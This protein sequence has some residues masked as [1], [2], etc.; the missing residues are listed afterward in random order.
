MLAARAAEVGKITKRAANLG[1]FRHLLLCA[2][3]GRYATI[4]SEG[5]GSHADL[6]HTAQRNQ[7][8]P[9]EAGKR[10]GA[11]NVRAMLPPPKRSSRY[12][13]D[14]EVDGSD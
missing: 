11:W 1:L 2:P 3:T 13:P 9:C 8:Y 6:H 5:T 12:G 10:F 4:K 14:L 7:G